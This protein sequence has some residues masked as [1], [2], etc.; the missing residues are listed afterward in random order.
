MG[1]SSCISTGGEEDGGDKFETSEQGT[2]IVL[3]GC[4]AGIR[5]GESRSRLEA[6]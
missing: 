2:G 1:E 6:R 4:G 3:E 5:E